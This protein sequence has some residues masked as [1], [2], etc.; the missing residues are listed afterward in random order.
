[1]SKAKIIASSHGVNPSG[2]HVITP[3]SVLTYVTPEDTTPHQTLAVDTV[4]VLI[5]SIFECNLVNVTLP[6][7]CLFDHIPMAPALIRH[8]LK[9]TD[10]VLGGLS[11]PATHLDMQSYIPKLNIEKHTTGTVVNPKSNTIQVDI[12]LY[13]FARPALDPS[14][15][16]QPFDPAVWNPEAY[17]LWKRM[18]TKLAQ[19]FEEEC[20]QTDGRYPKGGAKLF[21]RMMH[22]HFSDCGLIFGKLWFDLGLGDMVQV[23]GF[24]FMQNMLLDMCTKYIAKPLPLPP[25]CNAKTV[26]P[27]QRLCAKCLTFKLGGGLMKRCACL[28]IYYCSKECQIADWK[29]H[30]V[31]CKAKGEG[32]QK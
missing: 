32:K 11:F 14:A 1:M 23:T 9:T 13:V 20:D 22:T 25:L 24:H 19:I 30:S 4:S 3:V 18:H 15:D 6:V 12:T 8:W 16:L 5:N 31:L 2:Q 27:G 21:R 29:T 10:K 26:H 17:R 7:K 28:K